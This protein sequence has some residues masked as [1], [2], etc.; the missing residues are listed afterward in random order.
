MNKT[1]SCRKQAGR[2]VGGGRRMVARRGVSCKPR[3]E[4]L[5]DRLQPGNTFFGGFWG[6]GFLGLAASLRDQAAEWASGERRREGR[7]LALGLEDSAGSADLL[8]IDQELW[9]ESHGTA[10]GEDVCASALPQVR[11][12]DRAEAM[13]VEDFLGR[14]PGRQFLTRPM[15]AA[16]IAHAELGANAPS[17]TELEGRWNGFTP[18]SQTFTVGPA[19]QENN[20]HLNLVSVPQ[21]E[22]TSASGNLFFDLSTGQLNI[23]G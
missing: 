2:Q 11:S 17:G 9:S 14:E 16:P 6:F 7:D 20:A 13:T 10:R 15:I 19:G 5:E 1:K 8:G 22:L 3:V 12:I 18:Q 23:R 4:Y 21:A